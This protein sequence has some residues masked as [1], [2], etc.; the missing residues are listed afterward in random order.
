MKFYKKIIIGL[1]VLALLISLC[2]FIVQK[3]KPT[4]FIIGDSTVKNGQGDGSNGKWGWGSLMADYFNQQQ[5]NI[6]NKA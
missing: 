4:L 5:I 1:P 3:E 2:S 6:K